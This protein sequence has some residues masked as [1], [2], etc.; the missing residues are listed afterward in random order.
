M[1]YSIKGFK[2]KA[3]EKTGLTDFGSDYY[4]ESL[5]CWIED[6]EDGRLSDTGKS[7]LTGQMIADLSRRLR[8]LDYL[9]KN[10]EINDVVIPP[11]LY[12]SGLERTG[13][14][15]LHN[16]LTL[17]QNARAFLRWELM[18]P[19]PAPEAQTYLTDPRIQA[20]QSA[21]DRLRGT[22]LEQMHWIE[23]NDPEECYWSLL[24]GF[25]VLGGSVHSIMPRFIS[26]VTSETIERALRE[27][28]QVVKILLWKNPLPKDGYLVLKA[29]Q[30]CAFL[31][32]LAKVLPESKVVLMHRAPYRAIVSVCNLVTHI[33]E[34]FMPAKEINKTM[35]TVAE[36]F[37]AR[38]ANGLKSMLSF[39][40][41]DA[42]VANVAYPKLVSNPVEV[43]RDIYRTHEIE[44]PAELDA[45][46]ESYILDQKAGKRAKPPSNYSDFGIDADILHS[47]PT[48][49]AYCKHFGVEVEITRETGA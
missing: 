31:P 13:T 24:N 33:V 29:P 42:T 47:K 20:T 2:D 45:K 38:A 48:T 15:F 6:L 28:R 34:P 7:F 16:L 21:V 12:I 35:S 44:I 25:G 11:I 3:V 49:A 40:K 10:P 36:V 1:Q 4:E 46:I 43:V 8:V 18:M 41:S 14:T 22:K 9:K 27:Y 23:A 5:G 30:F 19:V 39:D 37:L 17:D 26:T 32:E